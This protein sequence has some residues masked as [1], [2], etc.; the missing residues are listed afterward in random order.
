MCL[1]P[2]SLYE[3]RREFVRLAEQRAIPMRQLCVSFRTTPK[4]GY[5]WL[6]RYWADGDAGL[7]DRS[8]RPKRVARRTDPAIERRILSLRREHPAWGGRKLRH[9]LE[10]LGIGPLPATSTITRILHRN[11]L[12]RPRASAA[13]GRY[14][15]FEHPAPNA[16]WQMDFKGWFETLAG[17]CYPLTILDDHSRCNLCLAALP[18]E[19]TEG[20]QGQLEAAFRRYGLP[21]AILVDNGAP[22]GSDPDHTHTPLTVW[23][24]RLGVKVIHCRPYHPQTQGKEER[25]H[26]TLNEELIASRQWRRLGHCQQEFDRWRAVYNNDRPHEALQFAVPSERYRPSLRRFPEELPPVEYPE[27][28][29][30]RMVQKDGRISFRGGSY[31]A[32]KAFRGYPVRLNDAVEP[33]K[34]ELCFMHYKIGEFITEPAS[35]DV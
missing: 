25:F 9:R 11:G 6:K 30:T 17:R 3:R 24:M 23:L 7:R 2:M 22:W 16:L 8:R 10:R 32:G 34:F 26:R 18:S 31:L 19:R 12:I 1:Q 21:D 5:K 29:V 35:R 4:T 14:I 13:A 15:R 33:D 20:V 27:G 28:A